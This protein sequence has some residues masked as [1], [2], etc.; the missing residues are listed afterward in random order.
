MSSID[1]QQWE[2]EHGELYVK[3]DYIKLAQY[4]KMVKYYIYKI[5]IILDQAGID[6][7]T[8]TIEELLKEAGDETAIPKR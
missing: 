8:G 4:F 2:K 5:E 3:V 6:H 7:K 1:K